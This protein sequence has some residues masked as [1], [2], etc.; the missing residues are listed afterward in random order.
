[1]SIH[2]DS[3]YIAAREYLVA[4]GLEPTE[5]AIEQLYFAFT[6]ALRIMCERGGLR[7]EI[8]RQSGWRGALYESRKKMER[9]WYSWWQGDRSDEDSAVDLLNFIGFYLRSRHEEDGWGRYGEPSH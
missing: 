6:P 5:D 9:L 4:V 3:H 2:Q 1:M 8:W 7:G